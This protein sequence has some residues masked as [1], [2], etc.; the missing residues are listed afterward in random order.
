MSVGRI[1]YW[2]VAAF[3]VYKGG[4]REEV[5]D[6]EWTVTIELDLGQR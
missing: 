1:Q 3:E 2:E 4:G 5:D 6:V